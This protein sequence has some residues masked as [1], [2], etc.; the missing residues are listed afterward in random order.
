MH[1]REGS[2][3]GCALPPRSGRTLPGRL[4]AVGTVPAAG[5][6]PAHPGLPIAVPLLAVPD[7]R[8]AEVVEPVGRVFEHAEDGVPVGGLEGDESVASWSS[9][10]ADRAGCGD[11]VRAAV[12]DQRGD[13]GAGVIRRNW[14]A[15][16]PQGRN[17]MSVGLEVPDSSPLLSETDRPAGGGHRRHEHRHVVIAH[18]V[19]L[20]TSA[21]IAYRRSASGWRPR[22]SS[23]AATASSSSP[24]A[25]T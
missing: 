10:A 8:A 19:K 24:V 9:S 13:E 16:E 2:G 5:A 4:F 12:S 22:A 11:G 1:A 7:Q 25:S 21:G 14:D 17:A 15:V 18:G 3:P 6:V 23:S 20:V